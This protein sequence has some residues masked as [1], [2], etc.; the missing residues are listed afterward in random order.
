MRGVTDTLSEN[1]LL[2]DM[3]KGI[4]QWYE[5]DAGSNILIVGGNASLINFLVDL[6]LEVCCLTPYELVKHENINRRYD[7]IVAIQVLEKTDDPLKLLKIMSDLLKA[8]GKLLLGVDNRLGIRYFCG[9]QD[10]YTKGYFDG[11]EGYPASHICTAHM[12]GKSYARYEIEELLETSGLPHRKFYSVLPNLEIAQQ[13]YADGI[14]PAEEL[15]ASYAPFYKKNNEIFMHEELIY[16]SLIKNNM[17]HQM[18][19]SYFIEASR[20][21]NFID[22]NQVT[23]SNDRGAECAMT[24]IVR[25]K[26]V[27][28]KVVYKEGYERLNNLKKNQE[29]LAMRGIPVVDGRL[30]GNKYEMPFIN[31]ML[32]NVYLSELLC[33]DLN[34]FI[35]KMDLFRDL[36]IAS[37]DIY[38]ENE[39]G[40]I[41]EKG[42]IDL[43]PLNS[44]YLKGE[45]VF[46][47]QEYSINK[48]PMNVILFRS[49]VII[50]SSL[51]GKALASID[52]FF[53]RYHMREHLQRYSDISSEFLAKLKNQKILN[54]FNFK[55]RAS[56]QVVNRNRKKFGGSMTDIDVIKESLLETCFDNIG[57]R[58]L[59]IFGSGRY[60]DEFLA[61]YRYDYKIAGIL[62]NNRE[63]WGEELYGVTI[64][65]TEILSKY[66]TEDYKVIICIKNFEPI[67]YQLH[68]LKVKYI[69]LYH[70]NYMYPG[71]QKYLPGKDGLAEKQNFINEFEKQI[72]EKGGKRYHIGYI[73]GVFDLYHLG[74]LNMFRRAKNL[75]DYLIV[76][77]VSDEGVRINKRT[78]PFVPFSE[79]I[80]IIRS[81][82]YVDEAVEI[83]LIYCRTPEAY[84]KYHFDVQFSGSDYEN[85]P[86]WLAMKDF[87]NSNGADLIF[88]PYTQQ[89]SS[90][91][92]KTLIEQKLL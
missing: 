3:Q 85:D 52:F 25:S 80:E 45:F 33:Y 91:K 62:D 17:F 36:I 61:M 37:S 89:T 68:E 21:E 23:M 79:R 83:P 16:T 43:V 90:T 87:L 86:G 50:Y 44:F 63:K 2:F 49:L 15:A 19:N 88:F 4:L 73:A 38:E 75:C 66:D 20:K 10:P 55:H 71:R 54:E 26:I 76:G 70:I 35:K 53:D 9:E 34:T 59:F 40:L 81:C 31:A 18:A 28:K 58:K 48:L 78:E 69:G 29:Y 72:S 13:L 41:L 57:G 39:Y 12:Q 77:V 32:G 47:D 51:K 6:Q 11:I 14:Y 46:F 1:K 60:A 42:L 84:R 30:K 22:V 67:F 74:H 56:L 8:E 5:F 24:T 64:T 92:I 82:R 7:Y 27:E 65:S